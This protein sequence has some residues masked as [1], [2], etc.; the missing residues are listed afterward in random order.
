MTA[1]TH[2][3][4]TLSEGSNLP[5]Y[6]RWPVGAFVRPPYQVRPCVLL[7]WQVPWWLKWSE[8]K[9][10]SGAG[11]HPKKYVA[12]FQICKVLSQLQ[13]RVMMFE[14]FLLLYNRPSQ[15][16]CMS[17]GFFPEL[18]LFHN[19]LN[20]W[21]TEPLLFHH[22]LLECFY[23]E[24]VQCV[25]LSSRRVPGTK[26]HSHCLPAF[27]CCHGKEF[28]AASQHVS[29]GNC[30]AYLINSCC[31]VRGVFQVHNTDFGGFEAPGACETLFLSLLTALHCHDIW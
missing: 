21:G 10:A 15:N 12:R 8:V 18:M 5:P 30:K 17:K 25:M 16:M 20:C 6:P 13:P 23:I 31:Q 22:H 7:L 28:I 2:N 1:L 27:G 29:F 26:S 9:R 3:P 19:S 14:C 24:L 4:E 11:V